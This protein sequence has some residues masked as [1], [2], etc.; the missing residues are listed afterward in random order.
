MLI[1]K[2]IHSVCH[3][4]RKG[5][6]SKLSEHTKDV[7]A[8]GIAVA[9]QAG[10]P[11]TPAEARA[12]IEQLGA[13]QHPPALWK[14]GYV[15]IH[16]RSTNNT[17]TFI[18]PH[19]VSRQFMSTLNK[20]LGNDLKTGKM[21]EPDRAK[22]E[23]DAGQIRSYFSELY[24][25]IKQHDIPPER[26]WNTDETKV[27]YN[28]PKHELFVVPK[29]VRTDFCRSKGC[30]GLGPGHT[31]APLLNANGSKVLH[32]FV[33]KAAVKSSNTL[34][35]RA[36]TAE[37]FTKFQTMVTVKPEDILE[38]QTA[39]GGLTQD[40]F[41]TYLDFFIKHEN[42]VIDAPD[43]PWHVLVVDNC[44]AHNRRAD[45]VHGKRHNVHMIFLP[46]HT[47]HFLQPLD[48]VLFS[49]L[50]RKVRKEV[51]KLDARLC[52]KGIRKSAVEYG[53][54]VRCLTCMSSKRAFRRKNVVAA[55]KKS[56]IMPFDTL[57]EGGI[58]K[59]V[60][61]NV[62]SGAQIKFLLTEAEGKWELVKQCLS[63][64][65]FSTDATPLQQVTSMK[66]S[67][68]EF[69]QHCDEVEEKAVSELQQRL[70]L[71]QFAV[72]RG[73][74]DDT[75][76]LAAEQE[77]E[78]DSMSAM[79]NLVQQ[80]Q[81]LAALQ[82]SFKFKAPK[83]RRGSDATSQV[84]N[85]LISGITP[86]KFDAVALFIVYFVCCTGRRRKNSEARQEIEDEAF[87][88]S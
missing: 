49:A 83:G 20:P 2:K 15:Q 32:A 13:A 18:L 28:T 76:A 3:M 78:P 77:I 86:P 47:T 66:T 48:V 73:L 19:S 7:Y 11:Y 55:F 31:Y 37:V 87:E 26:I 80:A 57:N 10:A 65:N 24:A 39:G 41:R 85:F 9:A 33:R 82:P 68:R 81:G 69:L 63:A 45:I 8:R 43:K 22:A 50:K 14:H 84:S 17:H 4:A 16:T 60:A 59:C 56:A 53:G 52:V 36:V 27:Y 74:A 5:R 30:K 62:H 23:M 70:K 38:L 75:V 44:S 42:L 35:N 12:F 25:F 72:S 21:T 88:Q 34:V 51:E 1:G 29:N 64:K 67:D 6:P 40:A 54:V 58:P 79:A 71:T 46:P 61:S